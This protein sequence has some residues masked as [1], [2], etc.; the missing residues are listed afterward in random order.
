MDTL[1]KITRCFFNMNSDP[2]N[3][4]IFGLCS[5]LGVYTSELNICR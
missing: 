1:D 4:K 2:L 3:L 5:K